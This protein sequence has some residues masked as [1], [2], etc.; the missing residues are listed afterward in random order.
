MVSPKA[1]DDGAA[2]HITS[3][4]LLLTKS[5]KFWCEIMTIPETTLLCGIKELK[6]KRLGVSKPL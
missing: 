1:F 4:R 2:V 5:Q 6:L 3:V